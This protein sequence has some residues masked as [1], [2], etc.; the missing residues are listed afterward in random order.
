MFSM[1][2]EKFQ[3]LMFT[4]IPI[5]IAV[6]FYLVMCIFPNFLNIQRAILELSVMV[7]YVFV[8][9]FLIICYYKE[10]IN[11]DFLTGIYNSKKLNDD[12]DK[13]IRKNKQFYCVVIDLDGFKKTN[14]TFGHE[15]GNEVLKDFAFRINAIKEIAAYRNGGDEFVILIN[16]DN[17]T[18]IKKIL[19]DIENVETIINVGH[20]QEKTHFSM[21]ISHYKKDATTKEMLLKK[22]DTEM[23]LAKKNKKQL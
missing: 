16:N 6:H 4:L 3:V 8:I 11:K 10:Q 9:L 13:R 14:D 1:N 2:K 21:G 12:L 17:K 22:A 7:V 19:K 20:I 23:Y 5:L 15:V 18:D